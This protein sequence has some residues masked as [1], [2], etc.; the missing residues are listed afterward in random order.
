MNKEEFKG[1]IGSR[2]FKRTMK[3]LAILGSGVLC[4]KL[5]VKVGEKTGFAK[6]YY[7]GHFIAFEHTVNWFDKNIPETKL[8]E[9]WED[10]M[11]KNPDR[12]VTKRF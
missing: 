2:R 6:G 12:I 3:G 1:F 8:V 7:Q 11:E 4:Y 10:F 9:V 5:G